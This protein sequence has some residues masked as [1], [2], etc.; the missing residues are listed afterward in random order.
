MRYGIYSFSLMR[1]FDIPLSAT[2][3]AQ[4]LSLDNGTD[5]DSTGLTS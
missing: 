4:V 5:G 3:F 2:S 1:S